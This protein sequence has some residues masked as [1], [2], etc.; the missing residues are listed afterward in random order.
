MPGIQGGPLM[1]IIAGKAVA[2][3]E[4]LRPEFRQYAI[5]QDY[6]HTANGKEFVIPVKYLD[7]FLF[8]NSTLI[9]SIKM[10][11]GQLPL[12]LIPQFNHKIRHFNFEPGC[13]LQDIFFELNNYICMFWRKRTTHRFPLVIFG[14]IALGIII[15]TTILLVTLIRQSTEFNLKNIPTI[16][17]NKTPLGIQYFFEIERLVQSNVEAITIKDVFTSTKNTLL[18]VRVPTEMRDTH[19]QTFLG[20]VRLEDTKNTLSIEEVKE[21]INSLLKDIL[22]LKVE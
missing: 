2:F 8:A 1:H 4:A 6:I 12:G 5:N 16:Q 10:D 13:I 14:L 20:I 7:L 18:S 21:K 22:T 19:L 17:D 15:S 9:F 11:L 3:G